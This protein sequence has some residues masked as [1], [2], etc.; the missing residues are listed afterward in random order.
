[1]WRLT[2]TFLSILQLQ[3]ISAFQGF[4]DAALE[5][6]AVASSLSYLSLERMTSSPYYDSTLKPIAQV[7]DPKSES[8]ATV[9]VDQSG[10]KDTIV[11][12]CR[13]S[14]TPKNFITNIKFKLVPAV[15]L[16]KEKTPEGAMVH[17]GFQDASLGLWREL[18]L[19]LSDILS[20]PTPSNLVFTGHS[21]GAATAL[22]CAVQYQTSSMKSN[23]ASPSII[24]FGGPKLCNTSLAKYLRNEVL[25]GYNILHLVHDKDPILAQNKQLW[26]TLGF[27]DV[28][29]ELQCDPNSP[30]VF[31]I[32]KEETPMFNFAWNIVDHCKYMGIFV[33]PR[34]V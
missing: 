34:L 2:A 14:A 11:V 6:M 17:E 3:L 30:K 20:T 31:D 25:D 8:G 19:L 4:S 33:G 24:T 26:D 13:G 27:E 21:L 10:R 9:F 15:G 18:E 28:G 23:G 12:A 7:E 1:M 22:L 16:T 29:V 5:R 32:R